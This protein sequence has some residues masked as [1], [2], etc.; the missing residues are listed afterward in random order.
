MAEATL[1]A[2]TETC[3]RVSASAGRSTSGGRTPVAPTSPTGN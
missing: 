3:E 2:V 1:A